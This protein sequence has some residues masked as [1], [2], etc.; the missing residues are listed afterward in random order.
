[1]V[2]HVHILEP[3]S[4]VSCTSAFS[5]LVQ[6]VKDRLLFTSFLLF[7]R[8]R[9]LINQTAP[10]G[11]GSYGTGPIHPLL[12]T[13]SESRKPFLNQCVSVCERPKAPEG[14]HS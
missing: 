7:V 9:K 13:A 3:P 12:G 11:E 1:M 5:L 10:A 4:L 6:G 14:G 8:L 2:S